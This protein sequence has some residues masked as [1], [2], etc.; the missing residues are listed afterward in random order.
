MTNDTATTP[1]PK[2]LTEPRG[3]RSATKLYMGKPSTGRKALE[4]GK[5]VNVHL[6]ARSARV[7]DD[8]T[9]SYSLIAG[10]PVTRTLVVR[11]GS[12]VAPLVSRRGLPRRSRDT[13]H[14]RPRTWS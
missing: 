9:R 6:P 7:L 5:R 1:A 10:Q 13:S 3:V 14:V 8:L 11:S 2:A 12:R 4:D